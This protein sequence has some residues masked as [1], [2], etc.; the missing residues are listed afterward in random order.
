MTSE[1]PMKISTIILNLVF[2]AA[3]GQA[4][5]AIGF[6]GQVREVG[7]NKPIA[8][9]F[10]FSARMAQVSMSVE[11]RTACFEATV[12]R[13]N[14]DGRFEFTGGGNGSSSGTRVVTFYAP[15][16]RIS[17]ASDREKGILMMAPLSGSS[18]EKFSQVQI[19]DT[20]NCILFDDPR[21]LPMYQ[22][23]SRELLA[24]AQTKEE[25]TQAIQMMWQS[26]LIEFGEGEAKKR[27]DKRMKDYYSSRRVP[28]Q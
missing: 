28:L 26:D 12:Q 11:G 16:Y 15:G 14:S 6:T 21:L 24:L 20:F 1:A 22:A 4:N 9:A 8:G 18:S 17:S 23:A 7:T 13:S 10:I 19:A 27:R 3:C 25:V 5:Q 2:A